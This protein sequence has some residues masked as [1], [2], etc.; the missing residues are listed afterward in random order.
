M[1]KS[2]S[3]K[4]FVYGMI[5]TGA[6]VAAATCSTAIKAAQEGGTPAAPT[7]QAATDAVRHS[8]S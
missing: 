7:T 4:S 6:L 5:F 8:H 3:S 1:V 2:W